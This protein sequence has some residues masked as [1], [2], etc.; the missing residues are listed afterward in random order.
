MTSKEAKDL[1]ESLGW[2]LKRIRG[3]HYIYTKKGNPN[4]I[5]IPHPRK[6]LPKG[7][8]DSIKRKA[9]LK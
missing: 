7:T 6:D 8:V 4:T 9:G 1:L 5:P 3:S 2:V